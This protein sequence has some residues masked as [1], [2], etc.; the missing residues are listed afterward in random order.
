MCLFL[1]CSIVMLVALFIRRHIELCWNDFNG[2]VPASLLNRTYSYVFF[3]GP[4][5][6]RRGSGRVAHLRKCARL[7]DTPRQC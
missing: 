5:F 3:L 2:T 1:D 7:Q 6:L 4:V